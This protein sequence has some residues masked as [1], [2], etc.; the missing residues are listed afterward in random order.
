MNQTMKVIEVIRLKDGLFFRVAE[1]DEKFTTIDVN[2]FNSISEKI[3]VEM[4]KEDPFEIWI[5]E[6]SGH[7]RI[8]FFNTHGH[9]LKR[10]V[11]GDRNHIDASIFEE[12]T[13]LIIKEDA[14]EKILKKTSD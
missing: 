11:L 6:G 8:F 13:K 1:S 5:T 4:G 3:R 10:G 14:L 2:S 9:S 7:G 12:G